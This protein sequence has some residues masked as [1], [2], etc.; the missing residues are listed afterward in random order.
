MA[1]EDLPAALSKFPEVL[2]LPVD[3]QLQANV[4]ALQS[5]WYVR[6][7]ALK[8]LLRTQPQVRGHDPGDA[9]PPHQVSRLSPNN[10]QRGALVFLQRRQLAG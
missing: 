7:L 5:T 3:S 1:G 9:H 2:A 8:K 4:D 10:E 6:G